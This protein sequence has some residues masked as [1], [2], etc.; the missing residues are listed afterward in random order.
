VLLASLLQAGDIALILQGTRYT[1]ERLQDLAVLPMA[2]LLDFEAV[3]RLPGWNRQALHALF[4]HLG[5]SRKRA[6]E[7][8]RGGIDP[9][10][11]LFRAAA[12]LKRRMVAAR[13][14]VADGVAFW[15]APLLTPEEIRKRRSALQAAVDWLETLQTYPDPDALRE[16]LRDPASLDR[17]YRG[18]AALE[19]LAELDDRIHGLCDLTGYLTAAEAML[20]TQHPW[21]LAALEAREILRRE[22]L[23]PRQRGLPTFLETVR[24]ALD[25]RRETF[26]DLYM[27]AHDAAD[28]SSGRSPCRALHREALRHS[29]LCPHCRFKPWEGPSADD[30]GA[31]ASG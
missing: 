10:Q 6:L 14:R 31:G 27:A 25:R 8:A 30:S 13:E 15:G 29:P 21:S 11:R 5:L 3:E 18:K 23:D 4:A 22:M 16:F 24:K 9:I 1:A 20:P 2:D 12:E 26:I 7:L 17:V 28:G 19:E